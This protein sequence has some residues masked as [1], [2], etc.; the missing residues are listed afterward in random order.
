M[1]RERIIYG[2][3][4]ARKAIAV[5]VRAVF[6]TSPQIAGVNSIE[7]HCRTVHARV[8]VSGERV[9]QRCLPRIT[10]SSPLSETDMVTMNCQI[11]ITVRT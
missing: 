7:T 6:N 9:T 10:V 2:K 4:L 1:G 3:R 5:I 11:G 8:V